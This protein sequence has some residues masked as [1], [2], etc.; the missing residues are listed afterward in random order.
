[1]VTVC[2]RIVSVLPEW[3]T[4]RPRVPKCQVTEKCLFIFGIVLAVWF[5]AVIVSFIS[6]GTLWLKVAREKMSLNGYMKPQCADDGFMT[7]TY[8]SGDRYRNKIPRHVKIYATHNGDAGALSLPFDQAVD[9]CKQLNATLW[10][11][12]NE[13][14]WLAITKALRDIVG[15]IGVWLN[16]KAKGNECAANTECKK[17]EALR[18]QG[19]PIRWKTDKRIGVYSRLYKGDAKNITCVYVEDNADALWN[20]DN[21][22]ISEHI[23]LCV[24]NDCFL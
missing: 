16:G 6:I 11:V 3:M 18:G 14:E 7:V 19:I 12:S 20:V 1:M 15:S 4:I 21:C 8:S 23:L 24:K 13:D 9:M 17:S 22:T 2:E 10:E 5:V